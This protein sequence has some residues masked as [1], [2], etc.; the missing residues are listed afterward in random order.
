MN[1][2]Q[3]SLNGMFFG[4][5]GRSM[6]TAGGKPKLTSISDSFRPEFMPTHYPVNLYMVSDEQTNEIY[7]F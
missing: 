4:H 6:K 1:N 7:G 2:K 3:F 5:V